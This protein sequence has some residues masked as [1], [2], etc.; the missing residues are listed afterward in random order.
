MIMNSS[1]KL[2]LRALARALGIAPSAAHKRRLRGMPT[3]SVEAA[4]AWEIEHLDP[5]RQKG[6]GLSVSGDG[7]PAAEP[8]VADDEPSDANASAYRR[9]RAAREQINV[10]L[11]QLELDEARGRLIDVEV[12]TRTAFTAF[13]QLRDSAL[14]VP[15]RVRDRCATETDPA[16]IEAL[17][18]DELVGVMAAFSINMVLHEEDDED[19]ET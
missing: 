9:A 11:A 18:N 1:D 2:S 4:R 6:V 8:G 5:S 19:E 17:L 10:Q 14:N 12:V 15:A 7:Q 3:H 16:R 13:R